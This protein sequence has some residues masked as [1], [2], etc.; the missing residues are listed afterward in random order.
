MP[1]VL[2]LLN[3]S[4]DILPCTSASLPHNN[5]RCKLRNPFVVPLS[6]AVVML[7]GHGIVERNVCQ[8]AHVVHVR[9][10]FGWPIDIPDNGNGA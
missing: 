2:L 3:S 6:A 7:K 10:Q 4:N 5:C 9:A 8:F 1:V